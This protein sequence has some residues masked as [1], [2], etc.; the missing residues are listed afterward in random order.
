MSPRDDAVD[1]VALLGRRATKVDARRFD[2]FVAHQVGEQRD[3]IEL[4]EKVLG[5]AMPKGVRIHHLRINAVS[6]GERLQLVADATR[7]DAFAEA[8]AEQI[9]ARA[10]TLSKPFVRLGF[11]SLRDIDP[12]QLAAFAIEVEIPRLN[13]FNLDLQ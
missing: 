10:S 6:F 2:G 8:I 11:Q 12:S 5:E 1:E 9:T 3:V 13:V 4:R 7:G